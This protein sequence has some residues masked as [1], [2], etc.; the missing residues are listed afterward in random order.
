MTAG[1]LLFLLGLG[2][3]FVGQAIWGVV[4]ELFDIYREEQR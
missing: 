2:V 1:A 3:G 4:M